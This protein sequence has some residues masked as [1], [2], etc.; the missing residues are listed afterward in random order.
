MIVEFEGQKVPVQVYNA[1][2]MRAIGGCGI[3]VSSTLAKD[4]GLKLEDRVKLY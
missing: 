1:F 2:G 3:R 4:L